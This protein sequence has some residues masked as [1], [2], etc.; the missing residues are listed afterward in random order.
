M[1]WRSRFTRVVVPVVHV[2]GNGPR[3]SRLKRARVLTLRETAP[4]RSG[5]VG[6]V[7]DGVL[8]RF[9]R[10][11]FSSVAAGYFCAL[12][13]GASAGVWRVTFA[14]AP[15]GN[16]R[17]SRGA[18][19]LADEPVTAHLSPLREPRAGLHVPIAWGKVT[20]NEPSPFFHFPTFVTASVSIK[21]R[22]IKPS[23]NRI[24][25]IDFECHCSI[26]TYFLGSTWLNSIFSNYSIF[27]EIS[28]VN[29]DAI[30]RPSWSQG[31]KVYCSF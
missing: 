19:L 2:A 11:V 17:Q 14:T 20:R 6:A 3:K 7:R 25:L 13:L 18:R 22:F 26:L 1:R 30:T 31:S 28:L 5:T 16:R 9:E 29:R 15:L 24:L 10:R 23:S 4:G 21:V 27:Q 12:V 8:L